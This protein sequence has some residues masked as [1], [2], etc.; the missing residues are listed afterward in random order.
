MSGFKGLHSVV[1]IGQ[2][3]INRFIIN[4]TG[5]QS[6]KIKQHLDPEALRNEYV[7]QSFSLVKSRQTE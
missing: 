6:M 5:Q 2:G 7:K 3:L 1:R 4:N